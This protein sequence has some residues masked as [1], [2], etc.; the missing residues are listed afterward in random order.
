MSHFDPISSANPHLL[1]HL[2]E[3]SALLAGG[4]V[5]LRGRTAEDNGANA[6]D[7]CDSADCSLHS[8]AW[9]SMHATPTLKGNT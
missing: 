5:R 8:T 4:L 9:Q 2:R 3:V 7:A 6:R 1:P